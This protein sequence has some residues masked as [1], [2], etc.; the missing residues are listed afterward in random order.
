M[1]NFKN[2]L[3]YWSLAAVFVGGVCLLP[4]SSITQPGV[5]FGGTKFAA[6]GCTNSATVGG[7][8]IGQFTSGT[9]GACTVTVTMGGGVT[10]ING[11]S[12]WASD[13]TTPANV[14]DQKSGGS[15]TT[16]VFTG[17]TVSGD[18]ISFGCFG[19]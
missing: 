17:T 9:T 4:G 10:S 8:T 6:S 7:A 19:Y 2:W 18:V 5:I 3:V 11:W 14:Y 13:Q 12:C 15:T 16:A 1:L